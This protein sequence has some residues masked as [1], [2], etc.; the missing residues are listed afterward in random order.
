MNFQAVKA[1]Y[2]FEMARARR[3]LWQSLVAPVI[4]R[5]T[6][7]PSRQTQVFTTAAPASPAAPATKAQ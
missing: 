2:T 5:N 4:T 1:I 6:T 3:T 7:V